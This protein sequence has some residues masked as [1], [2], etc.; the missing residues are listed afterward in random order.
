MNCP[1]HTE[2]RDISAMRIADLQLLMGL[3]IQMRVSE[4]LHWVVCW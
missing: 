3:T 4:G 1:D 2:R